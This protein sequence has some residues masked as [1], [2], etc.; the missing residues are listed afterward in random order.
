LSGLSFLTPFGA[1][2]AVGVVLPLAGFVLF[3]RRAERVRAILRLPEPSTGARATM[4]VSLT[5]IAALVSVAAAQPVLRRTTPRVQRTDAQAYVVF[6]VS[7]SMGASRKE[8]GPDRLE[9]AKRIAVRVRSALPDVPF[10][11]ASFAIYALPHLFPTG[12]PLTFAATVRDAVRI[13]SPPSPNV[14]SG[15]ERTSD[16]SSLSALADGFFAP[17]TTRGLV[18]VFT[19]GESNQ[20]YPGDVASAYRRRIQLILVHVWNPDE[21]IY[22]GGNA[23]DPGYHPDPTS[24]ADLRSIAVATHGS[25]IS[26]HDVGAIIDRARADLGSGPTRRLSAEPGRTPLAPWILGIAFVPLAVVLRRRNL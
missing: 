1:L 7:R 15:L 2:V 6:D 3:E 18:I 24:H 11:V 26:E 19:D 14:F 20:F 23:I 13:G 17:H 9:R 5:L 16:L 22:L 8:G 4:V 12:D 10:G 21:R 25:V